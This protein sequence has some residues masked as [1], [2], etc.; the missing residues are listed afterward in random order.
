ME[1]ADF[2]PVKS[3]Y[4]PK[5]DPLARN[6]TEETARCE[7]DRIATDA[8]EVIRCKVEAVFENV[9]PGSRRLEPACTGW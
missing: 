1:K 2:D 4:L 5:G 9:R 8:N 3:N 7:Y 6:S